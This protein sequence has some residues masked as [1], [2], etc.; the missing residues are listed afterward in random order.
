MAQILSTTRRPLTPSPRRAITS[1]TPRRPPELLPR[2]GRQPYPRRRWWTACS[3]PSISPARR[4]ST[5]LCRATPPMR[6]GSMCSLS[7][8]SPRPRGRSAHALPRT[9][10]SY[11]STCTALPRARRACTGDGAGCALRSMSLQRTSLRRA[12]LAAV[13]SWWDWIGQ[14]AR[15]SASSILMW[16]RTSSALAFG[17]VPAWERGNG[18]PGTSATRQHASLSA[19]FPSTT[20]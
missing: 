11:S 10:T 2:A 8:A 3:M 9:R 17:A 1:R 13:V 20:Q 12:A 16:T 19:F 15:S 4:T 14:T 7:T 6:L 5:W 18:R